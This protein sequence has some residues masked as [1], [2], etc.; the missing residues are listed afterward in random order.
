MVLT[1]PSNSSPASDRLATTNT[2]LRAP[3]PYR[4]PPSS[5]LLTDTVLS[6]RNFFYLHTIV[7]PLWTTNPRGELYLWSRGNLV[8]LALHAFYV[9]LGLA[10]FA[11][12]PLWLCM[13]GR[14]WLLYA[15]GYFAVVWAV[16]Q[17]LNRGGKDARSAISAPGVK[18]VP[19]E[20]WVF[21]NGVMAGSWWVQ[22][23]VD[24]L[25]RRFGRPVTAIHNRTLAPAPPSFIRCHGW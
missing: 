15:V 17:I 8:T 4:Y 24:E 5:L 10:G 9:F 7:W 18:E 23:A 11:L 19:D 1:E 14:V 2:T 25:A 12:A 13:T 20:K 22:S 6:L 16:A 3:A 21:V